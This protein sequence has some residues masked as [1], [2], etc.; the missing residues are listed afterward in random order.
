MVKKNHATLVIGAGIAGIQAALDLGDMG[1]QVYLIEKRPCIGGRM[2]QLDKTF[3]TNDCSICILAPKLSE[4]VRHPNIELYTLSE[5]VGLEGEPGNFTV[6]ILKHPRY[7]KEDACIN[8][9]LCIDKCPVRVDDDFN[10]GLIKRKAIYLD[11]LQGIPAKMAIDDHYCIYLTRGKCGVCQKACPKGAIDFDQK[12]KT[13]DLSIGAVIVATGYDPF[14]PTLL[15]NFGYGRIKNVITA[16]EMERFE[17]ASGPTNGD[18]V[19]PSDGEPPKKLAFIQCVGSRNKNYN[20]YCSTI[21]CMYSTKEA[22]VAYEHNNQLEIKI[23]YIDIRA[24]GKH[25][26]EYQRRGEEEYNITYIMGK[27][28]KIQEDKDQ[29]L[30]VIY[31]LIKTGEVISEKFDMV[32]LATSI[33]PKQDADKVANTL[34]IERD[35]Y[36]FIKTL[37]NAPMITTREGV[38]ACGCC[39]G[40]MDIPNSVIEASGAAALASEVLRSSRRFTSRDDK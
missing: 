16:I 29:N 27:V 9:G 39:H 10:V 14:D 22:M 33:I 25:F 28:G 3:P 23:F 20:N 13:F 8:C 32:V 7:I 17:C 19:R 4:A 2:A 38:Y 5:V 30:N 21:C 34:G 11:Y 12:E 26:Q 31:E 37:P 6:K 15:H 24:G 35:K 1:I 36:N 18:L 40:P